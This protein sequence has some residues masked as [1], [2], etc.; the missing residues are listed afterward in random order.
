[1]KLVSIF[2]AL[3]IAITLSKKTYIVAAKRIY[4]GYMIQPPFCNK[5]IIEIFAAVSTASGATC[6][7]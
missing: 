4:S 3:R 2:E 5:S 6:K 7:I 1:M